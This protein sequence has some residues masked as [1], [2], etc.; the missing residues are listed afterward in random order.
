[1]NR[2]ARAQS[3]SQN[4]NFGPSQTPF[5]ADPG[6]RQ[7]LNLNDTQFSTLNTAYQNAYA[8]YNQALNNLSPAL[9]PE[10]REVQALRLQ[11]QFNQGLANLSGTA[12]TDPQARNRFNQL[13]RQYMGADAFNDPSV[14][15]QLNLTP[16]QV[17]QLRTL[18]NNWRQQLQQF[19]QSAGNVQTPGN[20]QS[21]GNATTADN[22]T[23]WSQLWQQYNASVNG[24]L[25]PQQQQ[26]WSQQVGESYP[27]S[28][29][30]FTQQQAAGNAGNVNGT[31]PTFTPP[32][33]APE[34][35]GGR[36]TQGRAGNAG[37]VNAT[38]PRVTP[39]TAAPQPAGG[40]ATQGTGS[41]QGTASPATASGSSSQ[42]GAT[43]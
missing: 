26:M 38:Q 41:T 36:T 32:V 9:T 2:Q 23:Q 3:T 1:M 7:Q 24:V 31:P 21:Q 39:P 28:A 37:N 17:R 27:F 12:F 20:V 34:P 5:F 11:Q 10:Q 33:A 18:Q 35:F 15:Q 14:Q 22:N 13:N 8:R 4:Q 40:Q 16:A 30:A 43:R 42:G 25:T 29:N 6:V 19:G